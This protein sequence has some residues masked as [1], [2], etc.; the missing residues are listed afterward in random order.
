MAKSAVAVSGAPAA[1]LP[2]QENL[3]ALGVTPLLK[4]ALTPPPDTQ[5]TSPEH[6]PALAGAAV[7]AMSSIPELDAFI[8]LTRN[9]KLAT[10]YR[11]I[12]APHFH[13]ARFLSTLFKMWAEASTKV[14]YDNGRPDS[15][16]CPLTTLPLPW[17]ALILGRAFGWWFF[18]PFSLHMHP[19]LPLCLSQLTKKSSKSRKTDLRA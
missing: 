17:R 2:F 16:L 15:Q 5:L 8:A 13:F 14:R 7:D 19:G 9:R 10:C 11:H 12:L 1:D 18:V 6:L 4:T 3:R